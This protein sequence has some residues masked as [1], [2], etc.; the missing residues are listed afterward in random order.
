[1][2][3]NMLLSMVLALISAAAG[4]SSAVW[5]PRL[6]AGS[7]DSVEQANY[8]VLAVNADTQTAVVVRLTTAASTTKGRSPGDK[9]GT[10]LAY[11][12]VRDGGVIAHVPI[13]FEDPLYYGVVSRDGATVVIE[14]RLE[15]G[16]K[17]PFEITV[18]RPYS[19]PDRLQDFDLIKAS[20][21]DGPDWQAYFVS[22]GSFPPVVSPDGSHVA[23]LGTRI[24]YR[25]EP[26]ENHREVTALC[27][28]NLETGKARVIVSPVDLPGDV[29]AR[30]WALGW[31]A[32]GAS[33][34]A[35]MHGLYAE[36]TRGPEIAGKPMQPPLR[37][38]LTLY[39]F[40]PATLKV[41][42]VGLVPPSTCAIGPDDQIVIGDQ[43]NGGWG[44]Y[45]SYTLV[46]ITEVEQRQLGTQTSAEAFAAELKMS[47][48]IAPRETGS[49]TFHRLFLGTTRAYAEVTS[50][51]GRCSVLLERPGGGGAVK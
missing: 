29:P 35:I 46:P 7:C 33:V 31:S 14:R 15:S 38:E 45:S 19:D 11:L 47:T 10:D 13:T 16:M 42:R 1:M 27:V 43:N 6:T 40:L 50:Q 41:D 20:S 24:S 3:E 5:A 22:E 44:P 39:R 12:N 8:E 51:H 23:L 18:W 17:Q 32:D 21:E 9:Y 2:E 28:L 48:F 26:P 37:P 30:Y 25:S 36:G 4:P 49:D 34:Y